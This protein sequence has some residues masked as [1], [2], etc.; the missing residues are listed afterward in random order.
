VTKVDVRLAA[1]AFFYCQVIIAS[2]SSRAGRKKKAGASYQKDI[3]RRS[4]ATPEL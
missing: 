2:A 1:R 4:E 3:K